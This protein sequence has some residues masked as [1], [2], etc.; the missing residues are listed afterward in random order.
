MESKVAE[1][2]NPYSVWCI[3]S[4]EV[5]E[6][7][8]KLMAHLRSEFGGPEIEPHTTFV[9]AVELTEEDA[10]KKFHL[11]CEGVKSFT[12]T[13]K[14]VSTGTCVYLLVQPSDEMVEASAFSSKIFGY[15]RSTSYMPHVSLLY[16]D[17]TDEDK[18]KAKAKAEAFDATISNFTF[19]ITR[20]ALYKTPEDITLKSWEKI[21]DCEIV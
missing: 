1:T 11:A 6:R 15:T 14:G 21:A 5:T 16:G 19:P 8:K 3:P 17:L 20:L 18:Q 7:F 4:A 12:A 10:I 2:K 9:R 13:V